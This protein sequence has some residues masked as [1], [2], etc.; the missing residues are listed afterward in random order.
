MLSVDIGDGRRLIHSCIASPIQLSPKGAI[1]KD[2]GLA[3]EDESVERL[4]NDTFF[5]IYT[6][7]FGH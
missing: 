7:T 6:S 4:N 2:R 3:C 1:S 5:S